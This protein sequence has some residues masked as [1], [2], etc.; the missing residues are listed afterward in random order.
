MLTME[1]NNLIDVISKAKTKDFQMSL[2]KATSSKKYLVLF[3]R[4]IDKL[5]SNLQSIN[6][7]ISNYCVEDAY[8]IFRKFLE[9]F[10]L[11]SS[12]LKNPNIAEAYM[13]HDSMIAKKALGNNWDEVKRY[14][15]NKPDGFLEYGYLE[16]VIN[17]EEENFKYT[18]HSVAFSSGLDSYYRWYKITSNFVHNNLSQLKINNEKLEGN[19]KTM[20]STLIRLMDNFIDSYC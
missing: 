17:T 8:T 19:L 7:L 10:F 18:M 5:L 11:I 4:Q 9:T 2:F 12:V 20:I 15:E 1:I 16:S 13:E 14:C 3:E 6:I